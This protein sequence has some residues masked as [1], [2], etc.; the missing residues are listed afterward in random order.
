MKAFLAKIDERRKPYEASADV[1]QESNV[2]T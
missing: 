2:E 1:S